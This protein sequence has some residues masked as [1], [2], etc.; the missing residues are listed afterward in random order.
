M[1]ERFKILLFKS[2]DD[3]LSQTEQNELERGLIEY[4]ELLKEKEELISIRNELQS[5]TYAFQYG[6]SNKV[7]RRID[8]LQQSY[9]NRQLF[10]THQLSNLFRKWVVPIG[11]ISIAVIV[12]SLYFTDGISSLKTVMGIHEITIDD[13]LTFSV[14][15]S[16]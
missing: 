6:F 3:N 4:P 16:K 14:F 7:M 8:V 9:Q 15:N 13:A 10:L 2:F 12:V 1:K 5:Q 11:A